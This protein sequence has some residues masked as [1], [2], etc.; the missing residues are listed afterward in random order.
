M[1]LLILYGIVTAFFAVA[2]LP[3]LF[4]LL[5]RPP[6]ALNFTSL[7]A[8]AADVATNAQALQTQAANSDDAS[9]QAVIDSVTA[10]LT[11]ANATLAALVVPPA[12]PA[13]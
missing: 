9:N 6:M 10:S 4:L 3:A 11:S 13:E 2:N 7:Q 8:Q 12:T 1:P 5:R